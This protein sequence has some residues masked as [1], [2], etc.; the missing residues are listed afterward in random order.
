MNFDTKTIEEVTETLIDYRGATPE[1]TTSGVHLVTAKVIKGGYI[2]NSN[3]EF[4]AEENYDAWMRRG[5]PEREDIL[6]T[7]EA[8]LGEMAMIRT[9]DKI[10]LAQ[11]VI[12][13]RG[14]ESVIDQKFYFQALKSSFVQA[15][16]YARSSGTTVAGIKQS[17]LRKV[18]IPIYSLPVQRKIAVVLSAYDDL[19]E[20]NARRISI[21]EEMAA[22]LYREW[23]VE[24]R[25]PGHENVPMVESKL[26][27]V[28]QGWQWKK[29]GDLY[30]TSSGGTPSRKNKEFFDGNIN[31]L[32]TQELQDNLIFETQENITE[33]GLKNSSAKVFP[34]GSVVVAMY[35]ATIGQLGILG[36]ASTTNQA[37]CALLQRSK[38]FSYS[39]A[40][41][42]LKTR[43]SQLIDLRI[44]AAQQNI[45]QNIIK[46]F[47]MLA[48]P[49]GLVERFNCFVAPLLENIGSLQKRKA[50]LRQ[51]RDLLLPCLISGE[52]DVS[53]LDIAGAQETDA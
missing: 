26:G 28:P 3:P 53:Q 42:D 2:L 14:D 4:I 32:K 45:S 39:Y 27:L 48:P 50:L 34:K 31:W 23:F 46:E 22:A 24:F 41:W 5:L 8:P 37:C 12:L 13:L 17:E 29:L 7:T 36:E 40:F 10:A 51:T 38:P 6:I 18:R 9:N 16:L 25:F 52:V 11:R 15:E 30:E 47:P 19:I 21:L 33:S 1:K 35:G 49:V 20:N 43:R 44:G